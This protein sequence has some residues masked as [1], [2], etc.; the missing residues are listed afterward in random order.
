MSTKLVSFSCSII[1][2]FIVCIAGGCSNQPKSGSV[3]AAEQIVQ[4]K[5]IAAALSI[6]EKTPGS[7]LAYNNLTLAYIKKGRETGDFQYN[8]KAESAVQQAIALAP[9]DAPSRKLQASLHLTFH[10]FSEALELGQQLQKEFPNDSFVYGVLTDANAELGKYPEAVVA[11]QKMVDLKPNSVSYARVAHLRSLHGDHIGA[12]EAYKLAARTA[13]PQDKEA[14]SWCLVQLGNEFWKNGKYAEAEKVYD[15]ALR[16]FPGYHFAIAGKGRIRAAQ[17]DLEDAARFLLDAQN[18]VPSPATIILLGDVYSAQGNE[19]TAQRQYALA[20]AG[21]QTLGDLHD[22]HRLALRWADHDINLDEA[23]DI[24]K[25]DYATVKDIYASDTY[26]WCLY[27]KGRLAEART[28]IG[29]AMRLKTGDARILHHA[30]MIERALGNSKMAAQRLTS[31]LT[32]NPAFDL[33]QAPLARKALSE[34]K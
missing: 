20:D 15:E 31:A 1:F 29:E 11:A 2:A 13:D 26:A 25:N 30:G 23:L 33:I 32:L 27:K 6:I 28:L 5:E 7:P 18:R 12:V 16:N 19:E 4:D 14:Q 9:N 3:Q 24:A 21:E 34:L 8:S 22:A 10:R 17:G